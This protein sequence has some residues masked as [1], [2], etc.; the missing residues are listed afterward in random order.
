MPLIYQKNKKKNAINL[1]KK[2]KNVIVHHLLEKK[3][4]SSA[5]IL[6]QNIF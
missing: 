1:S 5:H 6:I 3:L 4:F 2:K